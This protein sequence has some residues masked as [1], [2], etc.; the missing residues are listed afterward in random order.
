M[1][2]LAEIVEDDAVARGIFDA[3]RVSM[4]MCLSV[5]SVCVST[6]VFICGVISL[7]HVLSEKK[8]TI[9]KH[10]IHPILSYNGSS[11]TLRLFTL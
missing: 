1:E 11:L 8:M 10:N 4:G 2:G 7:Y 6:C 3:A 5:L 9:A